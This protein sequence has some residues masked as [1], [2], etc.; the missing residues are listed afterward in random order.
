MN[1]LNSISLCGPKLLALLAV[2]LLLGTPTLYAQPPAQEGEDNG[3][4]QGRN[5]DPLLRLRL[6]RGGSSP[7]QQQT[8]PA[9]Q[10]TAPANQP[11]APKTGVIAFAVREKCKVF[12]NGELQG[13]ISVAD[14]Y[15]L[16]A[17]VGEHVLEIVSM[18]NKKRWRSAVAVKE[19]EKVS[20][21]PKLK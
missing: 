9:S 16:D 8:A 18:D 5:A 10:Q 20:L 3:E 14:E 1:K 19:G 12:L 6:M 11:I 21:E 2:G 15:A 13:T 4:T 17:P 7:A